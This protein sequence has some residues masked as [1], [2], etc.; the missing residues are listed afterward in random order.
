MTV[1]CLPPDTG[2]TVEQFA[3]AVAEQRVK[4]IEE[5]LSVGSIK[6]GKANIGTS[7]SVRGKIAGEE[8]AGILQHFNVRLLGQDVPH[9]ARFFGVDGS[10]YE[11]ILMAQVFF[12]GRNENVSGVRSDPR[13]VFGGLSAG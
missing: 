7:S 1:I 2:A 9:E 4:A 6:A 10:Q 8:R 12:A 5:M 3:A 13:L 11:A